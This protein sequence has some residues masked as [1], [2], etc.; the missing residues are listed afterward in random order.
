MIIFNLKEVLKQRGLTMTDVHNS[1]GI[2]K[3]T[4]SLLA[5][6]TSKG[7]QFDTLDKLISSIKVPIQEL[8]LQK[9]DFEIIPSKLTV[10][11]ENNVIEY[12][13]VFTDNI[14]KNTFDISMKSPYNYNDGIFIIE[15][16]NPSHVNKEDSFILLK[17]IIQNSSVYSQNSV[18]VPEKFIDLAKQDKQSAIEFLVN[19]EERSALFD[20][21]NYFKDFQFLFVYLLINT[22]KRDVE[23]NISR[24]SELHSQN[25]NRLF[26]FKWDITSVIGDYVNNQSK[27]VIPSSETE[28]DVISRFFKSNQ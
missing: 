25:Y 17:T 3:N 26:V 7:I 21:G 13:V 24:A 22:I 18:T 5:N 27:I 9:Q 20:M 11:Y 15:M 8:I 4:L 2:S 14:N 12:T 6:G 16:F 10:D 23:N 28:R 19:D 1:T